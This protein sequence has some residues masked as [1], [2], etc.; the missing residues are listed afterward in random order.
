M[1]EQHR[2]AIHHA[3]PPSGAEL[4]PDFGTAKR[5]SSQSTSTAAAD[6]RSHGR[7][8]MQWGRMHVRFSPTARAPSDHCT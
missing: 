1:N 5:H 8:H 4:Q 7:T 6:A 3:N 2:G